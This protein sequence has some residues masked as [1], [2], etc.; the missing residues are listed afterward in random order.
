MSNKTYQP[1]DIVGFKPDS[2][3]QLV[4]VAP[5]Q[6]NS[7]YYTCVYFMAGVGFSWIELPPEA[8]V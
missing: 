6:N 8:L 3:I 5:G 2:R 4:V 7:N 1:G